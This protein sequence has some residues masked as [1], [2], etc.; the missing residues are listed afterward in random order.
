MA[1]LGSQVLPVSSR[2]TVLGDLY[3]SGAKPELT[4]Q[5]RCFGLLGAMLRDLPK[6]TPPDPRY[7]EVKNAVLGI[8]EADKAAAIPV[9]T[10]LAAAEALGQA[11]DPRLRLPRDPDYWVKV[12]GFVIG[13]YPVTVQEYQLFVDAGGPNPKE[14]LRNNI[15]IFAAGSH[16]SIRR[17]KPLA[18]V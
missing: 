6:Y 16:S 5:A 11:G 18:G 13:E 2:T 10:R 12:E 15:V 8:F 7:A 4:K 3:R 17:E 14:V 9:K 1:L